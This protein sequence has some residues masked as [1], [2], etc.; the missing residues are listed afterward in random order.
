MR[1]AGDLSRRFAATFELSPD[2]KIFGSGESFTRLN[3]RGQKIN[4]T[5]RDGM[6]VQG[7]LM[8]KPIPFFLSNNGY[9]MFVHTSAPVTFDFGNFYDSHNVIYSADDSLD[10]FIFLGDPK[11]NL[12]LSQARVESVKGY[13]SSKGIPKS[14][15]KTKAFGGGQ[16]LSRENTPEAHRLNRRVEVRILQN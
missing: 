11:E 4:L 3:K 6:G 15:L 13:L 9:G 2:E 7:Q 12:K 8:Y 1:R 14:R 16:P 5:T 10:L